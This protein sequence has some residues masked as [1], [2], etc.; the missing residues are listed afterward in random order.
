MPLSPTGGQLGIQEMTKAD[1]DNNACY[2][3]NHHGARLSHLTSAVL[4]IAG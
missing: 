1:R 2:T 3:D 4:M